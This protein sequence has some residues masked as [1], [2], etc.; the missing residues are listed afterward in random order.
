MA[1]PN[2]YCGLKR[3]EMSDAAYLVNGAACCTRYCY[4]HAIAAA[5]RW[6]K[7]A[8]CGADRLRPWPIWNHNV[9]GAGPPIWRREKI[10]FNIWSPLKGFLTS[11]L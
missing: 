9:L 2:C 6:I 8:I 4:N 11:S 5:A 1:E 10:A 3:I 7:T